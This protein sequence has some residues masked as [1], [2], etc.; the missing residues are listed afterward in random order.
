MRQALIVQGGWDGHQPQEVAEILAALL[1]NEEFSVEISDTLDRLCDE[2][3]L[4]TLDLIVPVWTMGQISPEQLNPLLHAVQSGVG[5][6]GCHGGLGDSFRNEPEFQYMVGGQW[7][8]HPGNDGVRYQVQ[9]VDRNHPLTAGMNDF[10]VC[11]EQYYMHVDPAIDVLATTTFRDS[12]HMPVA[13]TKTY[14]AGRVYY[15]SLGH[16]ANIVAMPEV[17]MLMQR[18]MAWAAKR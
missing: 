9:I 5:I 16:Q 11:S 18:G 14:G 1:R 15:C 17:S 10:A 4:C 13:W 8:A 6:A 2:E 12:I 7:V 3:K